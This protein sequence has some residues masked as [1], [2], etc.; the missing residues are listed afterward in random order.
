MRFT[1][2]FAL[3]TIAVGAVAANSCTQDNVWCATSVEAKNSGRTTGWGCT[4]E[5]ERPC[6]T[7]CFPNGSRPIKQSVINK[8]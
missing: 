4:I 8:P 7:D 5:G 6:D 1:Q 2:I 3:A